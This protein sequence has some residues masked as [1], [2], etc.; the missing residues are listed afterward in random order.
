MNEKIRRYINVLQYYKKK[1]TKQTEILLF[2]K[3]HKISKSVF[4]MYYKK[5]AKKQLALLYALKYNKNF[6]TNNKKLQMK[7]HQ[8]ELERDI[9]NFEEHQY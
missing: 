2:G 3:K 7:R 9:D 8:E 1:K 4:E 6:V 5:K